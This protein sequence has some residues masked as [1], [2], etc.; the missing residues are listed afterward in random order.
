MATYGERAIMTRL[1]DEGCDIRVWSGDCE[2]SGSATIGD[3]YLCDFCGK[4]IDLNH[5]VNHEIFPYVTG[6]PDFLS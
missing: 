1:R 6:D 4:I 5:E 3:K 2:H